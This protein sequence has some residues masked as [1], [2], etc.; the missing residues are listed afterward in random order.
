[1][2]QPRS[3]LD[4]AAVLVTD[5]SI[6]NTIVLTFT[7]SPENGAVPLRIDYPVL[8]L[9]GLAG[10]FLNVLFL[11][12]PRP[13]PAIAGLNVLIAAAEAAALFLFSS[14][15]LG[16]LRWA[17]FAFAVLFSTARGCY[18]VLYA[19]PLKQRLVYTEGSFFMVLWF[20]FLQS[21]ITRYPVS[22][23]FILFFV[24]SLNLAVLVKLRVSGEDG[25]VNLS[26]RWAALLTA[27]AAAVLAFSLLLFTGFFSG[28]LRALTAGTISAAT[29]AGKAL[30]NLLSAILSFLISLIPPPSPSK[31]PMPEQSMEDIKP[32][33][34]HQQGDGQTTAIVLAAV[35]GAAALAALVYLLIRFRHFRI[36]ASF[37][38]GRAAGKKARSEKR[39]LFR[40]LLRAV[41]ARV[42]FLLLSV[43]RRK[44]AAG[45][46]LA[47]ERFGR[48][49]RLPRLGGET[50][51]AYIE[52]L[53]RSTDLA[54][55]GTSPL[56]ARLCDELDFRYYGR[57][58]AGVPGGGLSPAELSRLRKRIRQAGGFRLGA[59]LKNRRR[60]TE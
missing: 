43:A 17:V 18:L 29:R 2:N 44:T 58:S 10:Y 23:D 31:F 51:R 42:R 55:G 8:L 45:V 27:S 1:M 9:C 4:N 36:S 59:F 14:G 34:P 60:K 39:R 12:K 11:A 54:D 15:V 50:I 40:R 38:R 46:L 53:I 3:T 28:G 24:L 26:G 41:S 47:L 19:V 37:G 57:G 30:L 22:Y 49:R 25:T 20:F 56:F 32:R 5:L 21:G 6:L 52:R 16:I 48:R 7:V 35:L 13:L 33:I